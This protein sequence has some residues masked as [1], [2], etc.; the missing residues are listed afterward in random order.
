MLLIEDIIEY[1]HLQEYGIGPI[2]KPY[3]TPV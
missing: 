2:Y 3:Q 1:W